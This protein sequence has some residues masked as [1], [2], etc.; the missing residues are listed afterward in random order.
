MVA[1]TRRSVPNT[2]DVPGGNV[3]EVQDPELGQ[4]DLELFPP[5]EQG[6][7]P[8]EQAPPMLNQN[9]ARWAPYMPY[10]GMPA[11]RIHGYQKEP[12]HGGRIL[13]FT[14]RNDMKVYEEG[15]KSFYTDYDL[16]A[17]NLNGFLVK[18]EHKIFKMGWDTLMDIPRGRGESTL[19]LAYSYGAISIDDV[20]KKA[21][22]IALTETRM[23]Q[24]DNMMYQSIVNSLSLEGQAKFYLRKDDVIVNSNGGTQYSG[25]LALK[26]ITEEAGL[27]SQAKVVHLKT[28]LTM[29]TTLIATHTYNVRRFNEEVN[30]IMLDLAR[31]NTRAHDLVLQLFPAYLTVPD[32]EFRYYI[33]NLKDRYTEENYPISPK[34]LMEKAGH[35]YQNLID[36]GIWQA[37]SDSEKK[38]LALASEIKNLSSGQKK[39]GPKEDPKSDR[40]GRKSNKEASKSYNRNESR[41]AWKHENPDGLKTMTKGR[42]TLNWCSEA[43]GAAPGKGCNMWTVHKPSECKG[44]L[45]RGFKEGAYEGS[46]KKELKVEESLI[47]HETFLSDTESDADEPGNDPSDFDSDAEYVLYE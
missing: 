14:D 19:H 33:Q 18:I 17:L 20:R 31:M 43:N 21:Q 22:A 12:Y 10:P 29:L 2:E 3:P 30:D 45:K 23:N 46:K 47:I 1:S 28:R 11:R 38:L 36:S 9:E 7:V 42:K 34:E 13:D 32:N 37:P 6:P 39:T 24:D 41:D 35:K 25:I 40:K 27:K 4:I 26:A 16:D 44:L 15:C 8:P 5:E